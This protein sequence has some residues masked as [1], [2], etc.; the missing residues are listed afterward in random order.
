[1]VTHKRRLAALSAL[2]LL[3]LPP[4]EGLAQVP[5]AQTVPHFDMDVLA[6]DGPGWLP[7]ESTGD[8]TSGSAAV[9]LSVWPI[10][11]IHWYPSDEKKLKP[12]KA[13]E[14]IEKLW[15]GLTIDTPIDVKPA[16]IHMHEGFVADT[17]IE[18][19]QMK[20]RYHVWLCP[21]SHRIIVTDASM[22]LM[23]NAP[24]EIFGWMNDMVRTVRCHTGTPVETFPNLT[25]T[26]EV[27][28]GDIAYSHP[29][30]WR[31]LESFRVAKAWDDWNQPSSNTEAVTPQRGRDVIMQM[32]PLKRIEMTW[33][34]ALAPRTS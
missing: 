31:P 19:G 20:T 34:P 14:V 5:P 25:R 16:K 8:A 2:A 24:A 33:G 13:K 30:N 28:N 1:M 17:T 12:E 6:A 10:M 29:D 9:E 22:S 21:E 27:P 3:L 26:Y 18:R 11:Y 15:E 7:V 23:V 4:A 32:D